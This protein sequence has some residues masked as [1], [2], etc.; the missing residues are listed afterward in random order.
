MVHL[1]FFL[2]LAIGLFQSCVAHPSP[3]SS[4]PEQPNNE[5]GDGPDSYEIREKWSHV[6][7]YDYG[8]KQADRAEIA[9]MMATFTAD[10]Y[11]ASYIYIVNELKGGEIVRQNGCANVLKSDLHHDMIFVS[12]ICF[13]IC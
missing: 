13:I 3:P 1:L 7:D 9:G 10:P 4:S 11:K 2:S 8:G 12:I 6:N 5:E